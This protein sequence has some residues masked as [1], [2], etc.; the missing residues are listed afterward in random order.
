MTAKFRSKNIAEALLTLS[1]IVCFA[2]SLA[3]A[4]AQPAA[5]PPA[6]TKA[7][8]EQPATAPAQPAAQP[9]TATPA[10]V[11]TPRTTPTTPGSTP[12][13]SASTPESG[14][15]TGTPVTPPDYVIGPDDV[16]SIVY[17]R[18]KDM[19]GDVS[20]RPD[21]KVSL[22]LLHDVQAAGLTPI[23]L[24]D[25]LVEESKRYIED[26]NITVVVK[27]MN[28]RK[29]YITGE[30]GKPGP[31]LLTGPTTVLQLIA[32]AGGLSEFADSKKIVILRT[33]GG[34]QTSYPFNYKN[35][36]SGK[37]LN[38]NIDLKPGDTVIVP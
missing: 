30:V 3:A 12:A 5:A 18:D 24:R 23:E 17:W 1:C 20:V 31:Y 22:P 9:A 13:A 15:T 19:T 37:N 6:Q 32:V 4:Q 34:K 2:G 26:P 27:Q 10:P 7:P 36:A 16:L 11:P 33:D 29:V 38:Q 14:A 35:V 8:A 28:S 21:G 25:R